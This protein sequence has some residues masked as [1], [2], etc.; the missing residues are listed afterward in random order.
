MLVIAI[1]LIIPVSF[2]VTVKPH[3]TLYI[4]HNYNIDVVNVCYFYC[5]FMLVDGQAVGL[6]G[7]PTARCFKAAAHFIPVQKFSQL[8]ILTSGLVIDDRPKPRT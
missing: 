5:V 6:V 4:L 1:T 8:W 3:N 2:S 7:R